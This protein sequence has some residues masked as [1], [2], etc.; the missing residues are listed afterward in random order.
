MTM[1][2]ASLVSEDEY[3]NSVYE[4]DCEYEDGVLIERN[5]GEEKHGWLQ[6][7]LTA[8]FF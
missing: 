6:A 8:Y 7:A 3:L 1:R 5:V 4:P 2:T